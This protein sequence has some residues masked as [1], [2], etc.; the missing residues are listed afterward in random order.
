MMDG[1]IK[2]EKKARVLKRVEV[3]EKKA[4][5][6]WSNESTQHDPKNIGL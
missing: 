2:H 4:S 6:E 3:A 5:E 1:E